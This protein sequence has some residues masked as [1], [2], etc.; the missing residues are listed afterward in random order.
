MGITRHNQAIMGNTENEKLRKL[1][2]KKEN[3]DKKK[4]KNVNVYTTGPQN[5]TNGNGTEFSIDK[6]LESLGEIKNEKQSKK[7]QKT[8]SNYLKQT[9]NTTAEK[10]KGQRKSYEKASAPSSIEDLKLEEN[11]ENGKGTTTDTDANKLLS[12]QQQK[13]K[14]V[15]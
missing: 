10:S 6:V 12:E 7:S 4:D 5:E 11:N 2:Q 8:K 3:K 13:N 1:K 14:K 15:V 9:N